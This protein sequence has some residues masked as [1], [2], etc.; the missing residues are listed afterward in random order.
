[1]VVINGQRKD[2]KRWNDGTKDSTQ[3]GEVL[4]FKYTAGF[5]RELGS[6]VT[7]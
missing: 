1:M 6:G 5:G 7:Q 2:I 4:W 3:H